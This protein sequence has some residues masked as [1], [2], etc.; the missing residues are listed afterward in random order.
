MI[1]LAALP[2]TL[3]VPPDVPD[4][5]R[6]TGGREIGHRGTVFGTEWSLRIVRRADTD[7]AGDGVFCGRIVKACQAT[8]ELIDSQM[9]LWRAQSDITRF[10]NLAEGTVVEL[11]RPFALVVAKALEIGRETGGAFC[12]GM[13]EAVERWGFGPVLPADPVSSGLAFVAQQADRP[14]VHP[15]MDGNRLIKPAGFALDLNGIAKGYAV[16]LLC[17]VVRHH[18]ETQSCLVEIGGEV[19][20]FGTRA[21][22]MPFWTDIAP[23]G[24]LQRAP[25]RAALYGWACATSGEAERCHRSAGGTYSHILDPR[26]LAPVQSDLVAATVFDKDCARAD[27]L[28]TALMVMGRS[29]A[30][31]FA[32]ER[33]IACIL[34]RRDAGADGLSRAMLDWIGDD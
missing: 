22:G 19:K 1:D 11:P 7:P 15:V 17:D 31:A 27:A 29:A 33:G 13:F 34:T 6:I 10:N 9:S 30:L 4:T 12:P 5:L 24:D 14:P 32:D 25:Y 20:A 16:D 28:A 2:M 8:L 26:T 21:D 23:C 3:L 18:P